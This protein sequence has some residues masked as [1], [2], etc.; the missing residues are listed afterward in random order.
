MPPLL[1]VTELGLRFYTD[2]GVVKLFESLNLQLKESEFLG[3]VGE[4]GC[5]KS[6][7]AYAIIRLLPSNCKITN[8]DIRFEGE[9][10]LSKSEENMRRLRGKRISMV[11]QDPS[12]SLNPVFKVSEQFLKV[13]EQNQGLTSGLARQ[14]AADLLRLVELSDSEAILDS[15]P[16]ELSGGMQQR[17]MIAMA[18]SSNP[19]IIMA[20]EPTSAVDATI[21]A[22]I[23]ELLRR[24]RSELGFS[25]I[26]ITHS[27]AVVSEI[28]DRIAVMYAGDIVEEGPAAEV[29]SSPKHPYTV[30]LLET[31]PKLRGL[32][33]NRV[34]LPVIRGSIPDLIN[35]PSGCRFHPRCKFAMP[36][37][38][39]EVP[40]NK[41]I[42][43]GR[44]TACF[45]Y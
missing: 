29:L 5:G 3:I 45:L 43:S 31:I 19:K 18:L 1:E 32:K 11:F 34:D 10:L 22:Q 27:I 39:N 12:T 23:L 28:C 6:T 17:V 44:S 24:L 7:L 21:Q 40:K 8:G 38:S 41:K 13:I 30:G 33:Q 25:M 14:R 15:Y 16:F 26:L 35:P 4:S 9:S 37:C 20:D 36:I 2:R 42:G